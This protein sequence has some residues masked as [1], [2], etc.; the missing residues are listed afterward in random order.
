[1]SLRIPTQFK[2]WSWLARVLCAGLG[3]LVFPCCALL[4]YAQPLP[5]GGTDFWIAFQ[6]NRDRDASSQPRLELTL[7]AARSSRCTL[8]IAGTDWQ[9]T[10]TVPSNGTLTWSV[11][12]N[13]A[14]PAEGP[15]RAL[16][17]TCS[18]SV[19]VEAHNLLANSSESTTMLPTDVLGNDYLWLGWVD[20]DDP[21]LVSR[22]S[23][24]LSIVATEDGTEVEVVPAT[25]LRDGSPAGQ[26][27]RR[28][29]NRGDLWFLTAPDD[30]SGTRIR[31]LSGGA[32]PRVAVFGGASWTWVGGCHNGDHLYEQLL[33]L[34]L[35]GRSYIALPVP[36]RRAYWLRL[37]AGPEGAS[38]RLNEGPPLNLPPG[39]LHRI[40]ATEPITVRS[41]RPVAAVQLTLGSLC[42]ESNTGDPALVQLPPLHLAAPARMGVPLSSSANLRLNHLLLAAPPESVAGIRF[43]GT[44][45]ADGWQP[46]PNGWRMNVVRLGAAGRIESDQPVIGIVFSQ[47]GQEA[48]A[49]A[50]LHGLRPP[51]P[52][53]RIPESICPRSFA[54]LGLA[55]EH[56]ADRVRWRLNGEWV[57]EGPEPDIEFY[58]AGRYR[59]EAL[60][61]EF[62]TC[63]TDTLR[64]ETEVEHL[65]LELAGQ[66]PPTCTGG[67]D[68]WIETRLFGGRPPVRLE[69]LAGSP[70]ERVGG[71]RAGRYE[72][73][74]VDARG[75]RSE[76]IQ[77]VLAEPDPV[78]FRIDSL[79]PP[80]CAGQAQGWVFV[81]NASTYPDLEYR[82][83][84][85]AWQSGPR[86]GPARAGRVLVQA[87]NA[88]G[89]LAESQAI[90]VPEPPPLA[91]EWRI[92]SV[93]CPGAADGRI[94]FQT[95]GGT[96][97]YRYTLTGQNVGQVAAESA[98]A[99]H[100]NLAA[101]RYDIEVR[102]SRRCV[103][104]AQDLVISE[105]PALKLNLGSVEAPR[106]A[107]QATG[108][109]I[110]DASGGTP[111]YLFLD[112]NGR[113]QGSG[114]WVGLQAGNHRFR[115]RD[116]RACA[117][118]L[119]VL[120]PEQAGLRIE[121]RAL[122]PARCT[123]VADGRLQVRATG[124][125]PPY[126]WWLDGEPRE[127]I[128]GWFADLAG[129][130]HQIYVQDQNGCRSEVESI[131][132]PF[133]FDDLG[134]NIELRQPLCPE[135]RTG[136][137][138]LV[139]RGGQG[140]YLYFL[141]GQE[142]GGHTWIGG[143]RAG[144]Y[145]LEVREQ[146]GCR[147]D[148]VVQ[149]TA[150][151]GLVLREQ[152]A[153]PVSCADRSDGRFELDIESLAPP[154]EVFLNN[155]PHPGGLVYSGLAPGT[156]TW[157][158]R[159]TTGCFLVGTFEIEAPPPLRWRETAVEP[160][161]CPQ[162]EDGSIRF[163]AS[164]GRGIDHYDLFF[165]LNFYK[166]EEQ[167]TFTNLKPGSYRI[168]AVDS[169]GCRLVRELTVEGPRPLRWGAILEHESCAGAGDGR[170]RLRPSGG[171]PPLQL[172]PPIA[173]ISGSSLT[174]SGLVPGEHAFSLIDGRGC[175]ADTVFRILPG[176][177]VRAGQPTTVCLPRTGDRFLEVQLTGAVP[178][179]GTWSG[180]GVSREG[181]LTVDRFLDPHWRTLVYHFGSCAD[182]LVVPISRTR[183]PDSLAVCPKAAEVALPLG[184]PPGGL[185]YGREGLRPE[186]QRLD[187]R[188]WQGQRAWLVY[189]S[190]AGC[191]DS[192]RVRR[193]PVFAP[194]VELRPASDTTT[195]PPSITL[196]LAEAELRVQ[197][198]TEGLLDWR[199]HFGDQHY[200]RENRV[201]WRYRRVGQFPLELAYQGPDGCRDTLRWR[202]RVLPSGSVDL[203]DAFSPNGDGL[204]DTF[205]FEIL[206]VESVY[207]QVFDRWGQQV[208]AQRAR[209]PAWD[210]RHRSGEDLPE[211]VYTYL[212]EIRL[213]NG[214]VIRQPGTVTL[215]R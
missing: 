20:P 169:A 156:Y 183:V 111:P 13:L 140:P 68:G 43:G 202:V 33:P 42:D 96:P 99:L 61:E 21:N 59:I 197:T 81:R 144:R 147:F 138:R 201:D 27:L 11:P 215:V 51:L 6:P 166:K 146:G 161:T 24:Q 84:P 50:A 76:P 23:D 36:G 16:H 177:V 60:L 110:L 87:R 26:P 182:T 25:R 70:N 5:R 54:R 49:W 205:T 37:L 175:Q 97:P 4:T 153:V 209:V 210:G 69:G 3:A 143:L 32:C 123:D 79:V 92:D 174:V 14:L 145:R 38:V 131:E 105:P 90:D 102:D 64:A 108:Q 187:L 134:L 113:E 191:R 22:L 170:L 45:Q 91:L 104:A 18:D 58:Q 136:A 178:A 46:L 53:L 164:G 88:A 77:V 7:Q 100:E 28:R 34:R 152:R 112:E 194:D 118:E 208:F 180:R 127:P 207:L 204:N 154:L 8:R 44:A 203:P 55:G 157:Q 211:G 116:A 150:R 199:W 162:S 71:L 188:F 47:G 94:H 74:A 62:S 206:E 57:A 165:D 107:G 185:W 101:D 125:Q 184:E 168:E 72:V 160:A 89:C 119:E 122:A 103:D 73:R 93:R 179:G 95:S 83:G 35:W 133:Q 142:V 82:M 65:H 189:V 196:R 12:F 78:E 137:F 120:V 213:L 128:D 159:D 85:G 135:G 19:Q 155:R 195:Q 40:A 129:G 31:A 171:T 114:R 212:A 148:T 9:E 109:V 186:G 98:A 149:L 75:C 117:T 181:Q 192:M 41:D 190:P 124:G 17:L 67:S 200:R 15:P 106:C 132:I 214:D 86:I 56:R 163:A 141:D 63:R 176:P 151:A 126:H 80:A 139:G 1:M 10:Q 173:T 29:L 115:L 48:S 121:V 66:Q 193:L 130:V 2:S 158:V 30:L 167:G 39:G 172:E 52:R 198:R